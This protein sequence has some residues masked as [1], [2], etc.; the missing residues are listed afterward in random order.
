MNKYE[1]ELVY[2]MQRYPSVY[3]L[4]NNKSYI[5]I[6]ESL[7]NGAKTFRQLEEVTMLKPSILERYL[8]FL[9]HNRFVD[10]LHL[11]NRVEYVLTSF[12]RMILELRKKALSSM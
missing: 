12:G 6:L 5:K 4:L 9:L 1:L 8:D 11:P 10:A 7:Q 3:E 2:L